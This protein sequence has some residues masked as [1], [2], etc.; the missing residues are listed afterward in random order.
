[1]SRVELLTE[2]ERLRAEMNG[3]AAA[4]AEYAKSVGG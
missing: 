1:M 3:L 2:I 4:Q